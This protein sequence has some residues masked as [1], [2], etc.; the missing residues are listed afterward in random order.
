[1]ISAVLSAAIFAGAPASAS[2]ATDVEQ[3][4]TETSQQGDQTNVEGD[5][6]DSRELNT[7]QE[8]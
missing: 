7:V 6:T 3:T 8:S 5:W 2:I 4:Y 1:M